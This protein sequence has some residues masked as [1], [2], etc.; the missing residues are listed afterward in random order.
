MHRSSSAVARAAL[1]FLLPACAEPVAVP[2]SAP[3]L[4]PKMSKYVQEES[5]PLADSTRV[6]AIYPSGVGQ[7]LRQ[8]FRPTR[9]QTLGFIWLPVACAPGVSL[10][11]AVRDSVGTVLTTSST[12]G[13]SGNVGEFRLLQLFNAPGST[14]VR[15]M[16]DQ[17][18]SFELT[19]QALPGNPETTCGIASGPRGDSY[20]RGRGFFSDPINGPAFFPLPNGAPTDQED[21]P[22]RTLSR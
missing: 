8:T 4:A 11:V 9:N 21:L 17:Q 22:F 6:L 5:Q 19:S 7:N 1:L 12:A 10:V 13:L 16:R 3:N 15:L 2:D 18:Y 14:G 20:P